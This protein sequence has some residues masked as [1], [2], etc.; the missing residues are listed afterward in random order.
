MAG[1]GGN[2]QNNDLTLWYIRNNHSLPKQTHSCSGRLSCLNL[3]CK[4]QGETS[5]DEKWSPCKLSEWNNSKPN[6]AV[7]QTCK[8]YFQILRFLHFFLDL[9]LMPRITTAYIMTTVLKG[10]IFLSAVSSAGV[11]LLHTAEWMHL[12]KPAKQEEVAL[13]R[14]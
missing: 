1:C 5:E 8:S 10:F 12:N 13:H 2:I 14:R 4:L 7:L 3:G 11:T 6:W 9:N